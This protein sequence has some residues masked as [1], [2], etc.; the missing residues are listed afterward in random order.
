MKLPTASS[1]PVSPKTTDDG[2][3]GW[4]VA[5]LVVAALFAIL[6]GPIL[7]APAGHA[8][9][10]TFHDFFSLN[11]P[12]AWMGRHLAAEGGI[13]T[14]NPYAFCGMPYLASIQM[15][16]LYPPNWLHALWP[17]ERVF[18]LL[19]VAHVCFAGVGTW[20]YAR[21]RGL[22]PEASLLA[23]VVFAA[24][25]RVVLHQFAGHPQIAYSAA[26]LPFVFWVVDLALKRPGPFSASLL[27]LTLSG[28]FLAGWPMFSLLLAYLLP[29]YVFWVGSPC[30]DG[31]RWTWPG[32]AWIG[33][34][35]LL[36]LGLSAPQILSTLEYMRESHR[37]SGLQYDW[38]TTS[39]Y[40]PVNLLTFLV[41]G[42]FGDDLHQPYWGETSLW[43]C[44]AFC[45]EVTLLL[46][47]LGL[48]ARRPDRAGVFWGLAGLVVMYFALG[49]YSL[50][51]NAAFGILPGIGLFRGVG[52]LTVFV[53]LALAIL[54][55]RGFEQIFC[56]SR[57]LTRR[58]RFFCRAGLILSMSAVGWSLFERSVDAPPPEW[59]HT[60]VAGIRSPGRHTL[61]Q[62]PTPLPESF[63]AGS[64]DFALQRIVT[65]GLILGSGCL[66]LL[67]KSR[68]PMSA[69]L[70][71]LTLT[72]VELTL[73][74]AP[75]L[76]TSDTLSR[77]EPSRAVDAV[78]GQ[79]PR[80]RFCCV[81]PDE[82]E[83]LHQF[84][85]DGLSEPGGA[86]ASPPNRYSQFIQ[87]FTGI[88]PRLTEKLSLPVVHGPLF[89]MLN[90]RYYAAAPDAQ[91]IGET[92]ADRL[93]Q[94]QVFQRNGRAYD[95]YENVDALP[96]AFLVH[97]AR[98]IEYPD[99]AQML[100]PALVRDGVQ[101]RTFVEGELAVGP[102]EASV[103]ELTKEHC[104]VVEWSP[105]KQRFRVA[106]QKPGLLVVNENWYPAWTASVDG[107][108]ARVHAANLVM[109][110]VAL[111]A[112]D[113][114]VEMRFE[115]I[116]FRTGGRLFGL[117]WC[118]L[119]AFTLMGVRRRFPLAVRSQD[120]PREP[121]SSVRT[122]PRGNW[123]WRVSGPAYYG[124]LGL[125]VFTAGGWAFLG[126][127]ESPLPSG[128]SVDEQ[129]WMAWGTL[130]LGII[131]LVAGRRLATVNRRRLL[132]GTVLFGLLFV[133]TLTLAEVVARFFV[134][135]WPSLGLHGVPPTLAAQS[136][137]RITQEKQAVGLNAWGQ[138]DRERT[139]QPPSGIRRL[140]F[141]G[142][143]FLEESTT[144]PLSIRVEEQLGQPD[145]EVLNLGVSAS[146]P[147]EYFDRL[148]QIA[149][150]LGT[151]HCVMFVY[152]GNDFVE[153]SRTLRSWRGIA[154]VYP[155]RSLLQSVGLL[156]LNHLLTN[157][158]RPVLQAWLTAGDLRREE[159]YRRLVLSEADPASLP[160]LLLK[161]A[162]VPLDQQERLRTRLAAPEMAGV[163]A[164]LR[165][166]DGGQFR[167][168]YLSQALAAAVE[169]GRQWEE[170]SEIDTLHWLRLSAALCADRNVR[171]SVVIIPEGCQVDSR[172]AEQWRPLADM[173]HL[174]QPCREAALRLRQQLE[175]DGVEV[176]DLHD[177]LQDIPGTYLNVDGHW[178]DLGVEQVAEILV[179]HLQP[180]GESLPARRD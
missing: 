157:R 178:S 89:D 98:V 121:T 135:S 94:R 113:H 151:S 133:T 179:K 10:A 47:F 16:A 137:S 55:A 104:E 148:R 136:W 155:R 90:V 93:I 95:L 72:A 82:D 24:S 174:T 77:R 41:P 83:L 146:S 35:V 125:L 123:T 124:A 131:A 29:V 144:T 62:L 44:T 21:G 177:P 74:A 100:L 8:P 49:R 107:Q 19:L 7:F 149:L 147:D 128:E 156:G 15:G 20:L 92:S 38:A 36:A 109:R 162:A 65:A 165:S 75:Y 12:A 112:G 132:A 60:F 61:L 59:W 168:Y 180:R 26:W 30:G 1:R 31:D 11:Y 101:R 32:L 154:A 85:Y 42:F 14:W 120:L 158:Q 57:P 117:T 119:V 129:N 172:M 171:F 170:N 87:A 164:M 27:A 81:A 88:D 53:T 6:Y 134:P 66:M 127:A 142:D 99:A 97:H 73:F 34:A 103:E 102:E 23:A 50:F 166:P 48:I 139:L 67:L 40:P 96:Q 111:T 13:P 160:D 138:R 115:S 173:R 39:S 143:S 130:G 63:L 122:M 118:G 17:P 28:Q 176:I 33:T 58:I 37:G 43:E 71:T 22:T 161:S 159:E 76:Q 68:F 152:A 79:A 51:Y 46:A 56:D 105:T 116:P 106:L 163:Y 145:V 150:P 167:S 64:Y 114:E 84:A 86:D 78:L 108:P 5:V 110:A 52:K 140:A 141:I 91:R 25:G 54:A 2:G 9:A 175:A 80:G 70:G 18:C 3:R 4:L 153:G 126:F 69:R 169:P 45:G